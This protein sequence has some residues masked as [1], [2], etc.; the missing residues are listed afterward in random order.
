M[1]CNISSLNDCDF[2]LNDINRIWISKYSILDYS[3]DEINNIVIDIYT[4]IDWQEIK[5]NTIIVTSEYN[6]IYSTL[7]KIEIDDIKNEINFIEKNDLIVLFEDKNRNFFICFDK[8]KITDV[9]SN[10]DNT[11]NKISFSLKSDNNNGIKQIDS[12]YYTF[13]I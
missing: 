1:S 7:F 11:L 9:V 6:K 2:L 3:F 4:D 12:N 8:F 5:F 10:L 13:N